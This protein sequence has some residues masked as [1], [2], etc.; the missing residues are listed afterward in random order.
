MMTTA[1]RSFARRQGRITPAQQKALA[2]LWPRY[3]LTCEDE[4]DLNA[5]FG[6]T[7]EKHVEI[8]FGMGEAL[9]AMAQQQLHCD[10]LG[11]DVHRPGIGKLLRELDAAQ[12]PNVRVLC[13]DAV[14][15]LQQGLP[16]HSI[17]VIYILFPDPWPKK[18]HHKRRLI[19]PAFIQLVAR[20]LKPQGLL[21][22]ATDWQDYA[23]YIQQVL[24]ASSD[25]VPIPTDRLPR[26]L[27]KFEQRGQRL[28]HKI[29][30]FLYQSTR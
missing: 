23:L 15:V 29:W 2:A 7:A 13:T 3:G 5:V 28:G 14:Q 6:R 8:G 17:D 12:L 24:A 21:R 1:M 30:D 10:Y 19:Q 25:F 11:I 9:L 22:L 26:P 16:A 20:C 4:L 27:T 18:R